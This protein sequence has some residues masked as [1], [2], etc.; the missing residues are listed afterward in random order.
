MMLMPHRSRTSS[1][2]PASRAPARR[3]GQA[4]IEVMIAVGVLTVGFLGIV[5]L[6]SRALGL[7]KVVSDNYIGTYL[8]AEG[9]EVTKNIIDGNLLQG[10]A[11][12]TG[13]VN[14]DVQV[15]ETSTDLRTVYTGT[16]L[17]L[18]PD[19]GVYDYSGTLPTTFRRRVTLTL[20]SQDEI[21]VRSEVTWTSRGGGT[22][23]VVLEDHFFKWR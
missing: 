22:A 8:A 14:G 20:A 3:R 19:T 18:H 2:I 7:N 13:V 23:S 21:K 5:G 9:I 4:L 10:K 11:W 6:L 1:R 17:S 15:D 12:N 16:P